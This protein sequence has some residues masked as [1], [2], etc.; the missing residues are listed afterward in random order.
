VKTP[1]LVVNEIR[2][3]LHRTWA[4]T[5]ICEVS[6][7]TG[8]ESKPTWPH[9]FATG[10]GASAEISADFAST[11][12]LT[13]IWRDWADR[14][15][16]D[17]VDRE[18]R[19]GTV[20]HTIPSHLVIPDIDTAATVAGP[21]WESRIQRGRRRAHTLA[22]RFPLLEQP[23]RI[24]VA[25]DRFD[26]TNFDLLLRAGAWFAAHSAEGLTSRQVP[27]EGFHA[28]WLN[29]RHRLVAALAGKDDLGL[30]LNHPPRIHFTYLDR[31]YLAT[32]GRKHDSATVGDSFTP[33]YWPR[34]VIISENKDTAINF[35]DL[36]G[37]VSVEGVGKGGT[38]IAS[39]D[40]IKQAPTLA[41]WGDID[42]D[43]LEIL[44][45][46]R[47]AGLQAVSIFMDRDAYTTWERFGTDVDKNGLPLTG[48][49]PRAVPYLT[50]RE[51]ELYEDLTNPLWTRARRIEQER[52]PLPTA[53]QL[54]AKQAESTTTQGEN[55][56]ESPTSG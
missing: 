20:R 18:R 50:A 29:P 21:E 6:A 19:I 26:D 25:A 10:S 36:P 22:E 33:A 16:L 11:I 45:G 13:A 32:G 53:H 24:L 28:K 43:G 23:E 38:T 2:R 37:G 1:H 46:F 54:L 35:P 15:G 48:R 51:R 17:L 4:R 9:N 40:W 41:Y 52:I 31:D 47:E 5:L 34:V 56:P 49:S 55:A 14:N 44:N 8:I 12:D 7:S 27:L 3:R 39:F 30:I 42:A